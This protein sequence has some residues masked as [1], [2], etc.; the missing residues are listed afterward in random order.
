[1]DQNLESKV[2]KIMAKGLIMHL[3][4]ILLGSRSHDVYR[5]S[6]VQTSKECKS[7]PSTSKAPKYRV[8]RFSALGIVTI[9]LGR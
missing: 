9:G 3:L 8:F 6:T 1:M 4:Y 5:T 2:C 7:T